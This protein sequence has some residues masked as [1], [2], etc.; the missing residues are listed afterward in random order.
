MQVPERA[1]AFLKEY[2]HCGDSAH[3][4]EGLTPR[5]CN[6]MNVKCLIATVFDN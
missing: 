4:L 6:G 3:G 1:G 5:K 2:S